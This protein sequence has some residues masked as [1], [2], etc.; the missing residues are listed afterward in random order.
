MP[1]TWDATYPVLQQRTRDTGRLLGNVVFLELMRREGDVS[2]RAPAARSTSSR[3]GRSGRR[4]YQISESVH[5]SATLD[6]GCH[7]LRAVRD[8][9]IPRR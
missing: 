6:R 3:T 4:Y 7:S 8:N 9:N 5:D 1:W 2:D